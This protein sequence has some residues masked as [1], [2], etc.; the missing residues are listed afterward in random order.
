MS[1]IVQND[2]PI[3]ISYFNAYGQG[4]VIFPMDAVDFL[5]LIDRFERLTQNFFLLAETA[6]SSLQISIPLSIRI[7]QNSKLFSTFTGAQEEYALVDR[8][9][10]EYYKLLSA[11]FK[12]FSTT[13]GESNNDTPGF[14]RVYG[15]DKQKPGDE[16][17]KWGFTKIMQHGARKFRDFFSFNKLVPSGGAIDTPGRFADGDPPTKQPFQVFVEDEQKIFRYYLS[18]F[19]KKLCV[20]HNFLHSFHYMQTLLQITSQGLGDG[21][22]TPVERSQIKQCTQGLPYLTAIESL[23]TLFTTHG[24]ASSD[25]RRYEKP[26]RNILKILHADGSIDAFSYALAG[27]QKEEQTTRFD[28]L[29]SLIFDLNESLVTFSGD[30]RLYLDKYRF[31]E[32]NGSVFFSDPISLG[33]FICQDFKSFFTFY[34]QDTF[35]AAVGA[36]AID[37]IKV[38]HRFLDFGM[39]GVNVANALG[40]FSATMPSPSTSPSEAGSRTTYYEYGK[41]DDMQRVFGADRTYFTQRVS[42]I[43]REFQEKSQV[44]GFDDKGLTILSNDSA[45]QI[46]QSILEDYNGGGLPRAVWV[47]LF[48]PQLAKS[49]KTIFKDVIFPIVNGTAQVAAVTLSATALIS[50]ISVAGYYMILILSSISIAFVFVRLCTFIYGIYSRYKARNATSDEKNKIIFA[51]M[52]RNR[53]NLSILIQAMVTDNLDP[54]N[55]TARKELGFNIDSLWKRYDIDP[56]LKQTYDNTF[57]QPFFNSGD[58]LLNILSVSSSSSSTDG[59]NVDSF[60]YLDGLLDRKSNSSSSSSSSSTESNTNGDDVI[61]SEPTITNPLLELFFTQDNIINLSQE[62]LV[63]NNLDTSEAQSFFL[64]QILTTTTES[65]FREKLL[66]ASGI[67]DNYT[68]M[69][70]SGYYNN[71]SKVQKLFFLLEIR[72][73]VPQTKIPSFPT[74]VKKLQSVLDSSDSFAT[75]YSNLSI[76]KKTSKTVVKYLADHIEYF[77]ELTPTST[78]NIVSL[79]SSTELPKPPSIK[80]QQDL[81]T[82]GSSTPQRRSDR[83]K[84]KRIDDKYF[85][86]LDDDDDTDEDEDED[87]QTQFSFFVIYYDGNQ[88]HRYIKA[89]VSSTKK[90]NITR[91]TEAANET[92]PPTYDLSSIPI[93]G[94]LPPFN[95]FYDN[96]TKIKRLSQSV[97]NREKKIFLM[98]PATLPI[99]NDQYFFSIFLLNSDTQVADLYTMFTLNIPSR[100]FDTDTQRDL[101]A[102]ICS[103]IENKSNTLHRDYDSYIQLFYIRDNLTITPFNTIRPLIPRRKRHLKIG[104]KFELLAFDDSIEG[105]ISSTTG[106]RINYTN[107]FPLSHLRVQK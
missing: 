19:I 31:A 82:T 12:R 41:L 10:D 5:V 43:A 74:I 87:E 103:S 85:E 86:A 71:L 38:A 47:K 23:I 104:I 61:K 99:E 29:A 88:D 22:Y 21:T 39:M 68:K 42:A 18:L 70:L 53:T 14:S 36:G 28:N 83:I 16:T 45:S 37:F 17:R 72:A 11:Y 35:W 32:Q 100:L 55:A 26:L 30:F 50:T 54:I 63:A 44:P 8:D 7:R 101:Y 81:N 62:W 20:L 2:E 9:Y 78:D 80:R 107:E 48:R 3:G 27:D 96:D 58:I 51:D 98:T 77:T 106:T 34:R 56:L 59:E 97:F 33:A 15:L 76:L 75:F 84:Q 94:P 57:N 66:Y 95:S 52:L 105:S 67:S 46:T 93:Q 6:S 73:L 89:R 90:Y 25:I 24:K 4:K 49:I 69:D 1:E 79:S 91:F 13:S 40:L 92:L 60:K 102:S 64:D 65:E